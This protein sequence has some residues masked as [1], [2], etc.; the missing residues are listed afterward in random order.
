MVKYIVIVGGVMSGVGKGV[1]TASIG[2]IL[3]EYGYKV[4]AIKIDPYLNYDSG[5]LRPTEHGE[6]WVT[7]DGGEID[8][9]LGNYERFFAINMTKKNQ[10]TSGQIYKD[11]IDKERAGEYLG[12]T[13]Q[14]IPNIPDEIKRRI[15][16]ASKG[17]DFCLIEVGGTIGDYENVPFL[18]AVKSMERELGEKNMIYILIT[19]LPTPPN[20]GEMKTKPTQQAIRMLSEHGIFPDFIICRATKPLDDIRKKKIETYMNI[21]SDHIISEPDIETIY[22]IPLDL[23]R[24][25][26]GKKILKKFG[27]DPKNISI[28]KEWN[29]LVE[30]IRNPK[31]EVNVAIIGK[32][33]EIGD[34]SLAD[35]YISINQSLIHAGAAF[36]TKVNIHWIDSKK[37]EHDN[38]EVKS[39]KKFDGIIVPGGF[40]SS[41]VEGKINV[42]KYAREND[43]TF[44]G[45]CY[46]MQLAVIEYARN[47]CGLKNANS[48][49]VD[50]NTEYPV[51][52]ILP[53]QK[54]LLEKNRYGNTMRL[55]VYS[56]LLDESSKV[57]KL[58]KKTSRLS[59]DTKRIE[60]LMK[61]K[62]QSFRLG[63]LEKNMPTILMRHRHRYEIN[64]K[65]TS[66][67]EEKGMKFPG[68]HIRSEDNQKL[69]E[70]IEL[71]KLRFFIGTQSH[72]EFKSSLE[73]PA[74]LFYGFVES[75]IK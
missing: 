23:E 27:M 46:G 64:N 44:L 13:V 45:L 6:V 67:L 32:Y 49:E 41:G 19:Y 53:S 30:K 5:T 75:M 4:T 16:E 63:V 62:S 58:Y 24:E 70:F 15:R 3:Q 56:A 34:Y 51:V 2:K 26:V 40:G 54:E 28:L 9:D 39:I 7:D 71:P 50:K 21:P 69:M 36:N 55:G 59:R 74:P 42:I 20:I 31:N 8:Q 60:E 33:V 57:Y 25:N 22:Q 12:Q 61:D 14:F 18:F 52:D 43:I 72:P 66:L 17:Y 68:Y 65:F 73:D 1:T 11:V 29:K 35:S 47:M 37:F 10:I 48:T 38:E